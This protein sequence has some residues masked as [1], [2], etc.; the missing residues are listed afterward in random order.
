[1]YT[2]IPTDMAL[3]LINNYLLES[4]HQFGLS[5]NMVLAINAARE[6]VMNRNIICFGDT[7]HWQFSGTAMGTPH[8]SSMGY[9]FLC[10][11]R[12]ATDPQME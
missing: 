3:P 4:G 1:M 10:S 12:T 2:N 7:Y 8:C 6:I 11:E 9:H 5:H